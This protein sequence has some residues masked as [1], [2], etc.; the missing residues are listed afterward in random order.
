MHVSFQTHFHVW[1]QQ[2]K[3]QQKENQLTLSYFGCEGSGRGKPHY[4]TP[5]EASLGKS[6]ISLT[7]ANCL[8]QLSD[9][10]L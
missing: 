9:L 5:E 6:V 8:F 3:E 2:E 4:H 7:N 10:E 1:Q